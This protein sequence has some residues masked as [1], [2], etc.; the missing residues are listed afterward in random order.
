MAGNVKS[1]NSAMGVS[2]L[3]FSDVLLIVLLAV[4]LVYCLPR[5]I[6]AIWAASAVR[7]GSPVGCKQILVRQP[8]NHHEQKQGTQSPVQAGAAAA[9][10]PE[11]Q[12]GSS[13]P[14]RI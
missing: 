14:W 6:H 12:G 9:A 1:H 2:T 5:R 8:A 11:A 3:Q 4:V 7:S 10:E 13:S